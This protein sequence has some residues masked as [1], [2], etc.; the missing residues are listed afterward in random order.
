MTSLR[1]CPSLVGSDFG[2]YP[3]QRF[4]MVSVSLIKQGDKGAML[5]IEVESLTLILPSAEINQS[6]LNLFR[7]VC[8]LESKL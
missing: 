7:V 3:M 6:Q 8:F 2:G 5:P 1:C 4:F